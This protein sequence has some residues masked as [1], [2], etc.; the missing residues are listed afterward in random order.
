MC[1]YAGDAALSQLREEKEF[2]EGQVNKKETF[3][4]SSKIHLE[5]VHTSLLKCGSCSA[6]ISLLH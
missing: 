2:A 4:F 5:F 1:L 6:F 3:L